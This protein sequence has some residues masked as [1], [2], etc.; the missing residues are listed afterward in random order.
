[1]ESARAPGLDPPG[2]TSPQ[3]GP[4]YDPGEVRKLACDP[5]ARRL[6]RTA[7]AGCLALRLPLDVIW[8]TLAALDDAKCEFIKTLDSDKRPGEKLDVYDALIC[9]TQVYIK[10]KIAQSHELPKL[11][12][13]LSFKRNTYYD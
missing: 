2:T 8:E 13:V 3:P 10:I 1:M 6:T 11:L 7:V 4:R 12:V 5:R 9:G